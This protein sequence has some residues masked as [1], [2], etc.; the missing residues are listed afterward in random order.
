MVL[1]KAV[2]RLAILTSATLMGIV[3]LF[4]KLMPL[5]TFGVV[6]FRGFFGLIW[7]SAILVLMRRTASIRKLCRYPKLVFVIAACSTGTIAL[8]FLC[9]SALG[10]AVA[11]FLLYLGN[12]FAVLF[13]RLFLKEPLSKITY[14]SYGLAVAGVVLIMQPW[15][16]ATFNVAILLGIG[17]AL[18]LGV[19]NVSKRMIFRV[20]EADTREGKPTVQEA[21]AG[22]AWFTVLGLAVTFSFQWFLEGAAM[23]TWAAILPGILLGLIPTALAFTLFNIGIQADRSGNVLI[24]SYIEPFVAAIMGAVVLGRFSVFVLVGG[25]CIIVGNIIALIAKPGHSPEI[26]LEKGNERRIKVHTAV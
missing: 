21:S 16:S 22:L 5:S 4:V 2:P 18:V 20:I 13:M 25:S 9:I 3:G 23:V 8:Y 19:Q 12:L 24:L 10:L 7:M 26:A 1:A 15:S 14:T 6:E 17:S 11:A